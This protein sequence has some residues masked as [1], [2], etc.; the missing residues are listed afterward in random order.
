MRQIRLK[1]N[2][3]PKDTPMSKGTH[4]NIYVLS[5]T[6]NE[7]SYLSNACKS[8]TTIIDKHDLTQ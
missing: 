7:P 5:Y 2:Q 3:Y 4:V 1:S 6:K 8:V